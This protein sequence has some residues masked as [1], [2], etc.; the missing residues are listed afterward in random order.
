MRDLSSQ[1]AKQLH[2]AENWISQQKAN[3]ITKLEEL[4]RYQSIQSHKSND[5]PPDADNMYCKQKTQ[6]DGIT[7]SM[8]GTHCIV[9]ADGLNVPQP[10]NGV[11]VTE[12]SIGSSPASNTS[13]VIKDPWI[14]NVM[15]SAKKTEV[16]MIEYIAKESTPLSHDNS[17][18]E[19][20]RMENRRRH[21]DSRER[22]MTDS[23]TLADTKGAEAK[24][25][26]DL[27]TRNKNIRRDSEAIRAAATL[28][29]GNQKNSTKVSSV[30]KTAINGSTIPA[31]VTSV[32]GLIVGSIM[33]E[34]V[35]LASLNLERAAAAK[36]V[37]DTATSLSRLQQVKKSEKN[38]H[39]LQL[40]ED[41]VSNDSAMYKTIKQTGKKEVHAEGCPNGMA[42]AAATEPS[43]SHSMVLENVA[44]TK[45]SEVGWYA[46]EPLHEELQQQ[47]G[48]PILPGENQTSYGNRANS[49]LETTYHDKEA[50]ASCTEV[51]VTTELNDWLDRKTTLDY[52]GRPGGPWKQNSDGLASRVQ[53]VA[54]PADYFNVANVVQQSSD[55]WQQGAE[56]FESKTDDGTVDH[57]K[58]THMVPWPDNTWVKH[59]ATGNPRRYH[60][61][62]QRNAVSRSGYEERASRRHLFHESP[63]P[64]RLRWMPKY[65]FHPPSDAQDNGVPEWF[66][67]SHQIAEGDGGVDLQGGEGNVSMSFV[68]ENLMIWNEKEWE[69]QQPFPA[70]HRLG[71]QQG[72]RGHGWYQGS[73]RDTDVD[74]Q[75]GR[76]RHSEYH[77][78]EPVRYRHA[79]PDIQWNL[80]GA[81]NY[82][83][84]VSP[85]AGVHMQRRY[86]I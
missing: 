60:V 42:V 76:G 38:Q 23:K 79:A 75:R 83:P 2:D 17:T 47:N 46:H 1:A 21:F 77:F 9:S 65:T 15:S 25:H 30:H 22:N 45:K 29:F 12:V 55:Q 62:G 31:K 5:A 41:S 57:S 86:Y 68:D 66:H 56:Q 63:A 80:G 72:G 73:G 18:P 85:S 44:T 20:L 50:P 74:S 37:H 39:G 51:K 8:A 11:K 61:E 7:S 59:R 6:G 40:A 26:E 32:T 81:D 24:S 16:N 27:L 19:H 71:Q 49:N 58:Q 70:P 53:N 4:R 13:G 14:H 48:V 33:I 84:L 35:S 34:D 69:Y 10:V 78:V 64:S 3:A 54:E 67:D 36:E 43:E 82:R 52:Q 28:V